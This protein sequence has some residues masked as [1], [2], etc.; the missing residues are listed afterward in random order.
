MRFI[1]SILSRVYET[2]TRGF[3]D[4]DRFLEA[5]KPLETKTSTFLF[6]KSNINVNIDLCCYLKMLSKNT[7]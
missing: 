5:N 7:V 1:N 4:G 2:T 3:K 6:I